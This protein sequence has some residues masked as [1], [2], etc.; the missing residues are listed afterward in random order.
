MWVPQAWR[1]RCGSHFFGSRPRASAIAF[2]VRPTERTFNRSTERFRP[3]R[4]SNAEVSNLIFFSSLARIGNQALRAAALAQSP[5]ITNR[6]LRPLPRVTRTS[7]SRKSSTLMP[8]TSA[9]RKPLPYSNS[10]NTR[11]RSGEAVGISPSRSRLT[12]A[13]FGTSGSAHRRRG[14]GMV[15]IKLAARAGLPS[16]V[17]CKSSLPRRAFSGSTTGNHD[18]ALKLLK[19]TVKAIGRQSLIEPRLLV[20]LRDCSIS[21]V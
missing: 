5:T 1:K 7:S 16:A 3:T 8:T 4:N 11:S 20:D 18:N 21:C 14:P 19:Q 9:A 17:T 6:F 13:S 12:C 15:S 10:R 2:T